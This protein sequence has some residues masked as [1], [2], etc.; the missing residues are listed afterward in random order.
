[1]P[2]SPLEYLQHILDETEYLLNSSSA[3]DKVAF[4]KDETLKRAYVRSIEVIGEA[5]KQIPDN[6]RQK[7]AGIEWRSIAGM[8]DRLIHG[9][10]GVDYDIVW[11]VIANKIPVLDKEI[12]EILDREYP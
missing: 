12:K 4:L 7:Y 3:V 9:Y 2:P 6:L 11:D 1:M 8:R 10:F 5:V